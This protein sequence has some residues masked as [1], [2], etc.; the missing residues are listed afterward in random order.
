MN[1]SLRIKR[2][3][4]VLLAFLFLQT[5][6]LIFAQETIWTGQFN[7]NWSTSA[8]WTNGVPTSGM[9]ATIPSFVVRNPIISGTVNLDFV[10]QNF[11]YIEIAADAEVYNQAT[12]LNYASGAM[13]NLGLMVNLGTLVFDNDGIFE[14]RG[15]VRNY[16][17]IDNGGP[18]SAAVFL[19]TA[20]GIFINESNSFF[21][22]T[23][24]IENLG[25]WYIN[26]NSS[27]FNYHFTYN[28]GIVYN[29][30]T[31]E[32][33]QCARFI[34]DVNV[35]LGGDF[36]NYGALYL[37]KGDVHYMNMDGGMMMNNMQ[38]APT[39]TAVGV[40]ISVNLGIDG[41]ITVNPDLVNG[42]SYGPC[43]IKSINLFPKVFTCDNVGLNIA[44]LEVIDYNGFKSSTTV[45]INVL[46]S[47]ACNQVTEC[48]TPVTR[49]NFDARASEGTSS[50]LPFGLSCI[51]ADI[52]N[53]G[54][55]VN[56]NTNDFATIGS[57]LSVGCSQYIEVRSNTEFDAGYEAGFI[58]QDGA[59]LLTLEALDRITI[60]TYRGSRFRE[61][62]SGNALLNVGLLDDNR[63]RAIGFTTSKSF[64]RIRVVVSSGVGLLGDLRVYNAYVSPDDNGNGTPDC[65]ENNHPPVP[66]LCA[67]DGNFLSG[68]AGLFAGLDVESILDLALTHQDGSDYPLIIGHPGRALKFTKRSFR[69]IINSYPCRSLKL[70]KLAIGTLD[71]IDGLNL[72]NILPLHYGKLDNVL[73][74]NTLLLALNTRIDIKKLDVKLS[75]LCI[76]IPISLRAH[77]DA[78][79]TVAALLNL[80]NDALGGHADAALYADINATLGLV[81]NF[82]ITCSEP[83]GT[84]LGKVAGD[85]LDLK[86]T[87]KGNIVDLGWVNNTGFKN[88]EFEIE[89]SFDGIHFETISKVA[90]E[91]DGDQTRY[92]NA[93]DG[94][95]LGGEVFY[96]ISANHADGTKSVSGIEAVYLEGNLDFAMAYP[97]PVTNGHFTVNLRPHLGQACLVTVVDAL[98]KVVRTFDI[99]EVQSEI[100]EID[101]SQNV[102]GLYNVRINAFDRKAYSLPVMVQKF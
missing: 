24:Q 71:V 74:S 90:S 18:N 12:L 62:V 22:N 59:G 67:F 25:K 15:T 102:D 47:E 56:D 98:G 45:K 100:L 37:L 4:L 3:R 64:D 9:T 97:N 8:N 44:T 66:P 93:T 30:G 11:N 78:D 76:D 84:I 16:G 58:V 1:N 36:W 7:N 28:A 96:R 79:A 27:V 70:N 17:S 53:R 88:E 57:L 26:N 23:G 101:M 81:L 40:D 68:H 73:L 89:R 49:G 52:N 80:A 86:A 39:P 99:D 83:C 50:A 91:H 42:G 85:I 38:D 19:N 87:A 14:N 61:A 20:L 10:L 41:T 21:N 34:H 92:Y 35:Y 2:V 43:Y 72:L 6:V 31:F 46:P 94:N 95:P 60:M 13:V 48:F 51:G 65:K 32:N 54:R 63:I 75:A 29:S 77:L 69:S 55:V 33:Y 82:W 5:Q